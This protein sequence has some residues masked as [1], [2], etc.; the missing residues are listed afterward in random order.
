MTIGEASETVTGRAMTTGWSMVNWIVGAGVTTTRGGG[1][2]RAANMIAD[3]QMATRKVTKLV[4]RV[5]A[6]GNRLQ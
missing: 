3:L 6:D 4:T 5:T 1:S 2:S